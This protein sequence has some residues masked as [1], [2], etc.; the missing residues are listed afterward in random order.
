MKIVQINTFSNKSTGSIMMNIHKELLN[1]GHDSYVVWARGRKA[2]ND[3]EIFIGDKIGIILHGLFTRLTDKTGFASKNAT[4]KLLKSLDIIKPDVIHLHNIHGYYINIEL[5]FNYIKKNNIRTI[6]TLHDCWPFT[7]HCYNCEL[8]KCNKWKEEGCH[9]CPQTKVYPKSFKDNSKWN[10][11][12][13]KEIFTGVKDLTIVTPSNWLADLV[14]KSFLK[15]YNTV[16]I[17]NGVDTN[18]FKPRESDFR[19]KYNLDNKKIL[20]GVQ[21]DWSKLKGLDDFIELSK[22]ISDDYKI[23]L[24]GLNDKQLKEIPDNVIGIK[25]TDSAIQLAEIYTAA[26]VYLNLSYAEN[27]P[28]TNLEAQACGT[29]VVTYNVGG[30]PESAVEYGMVID[31]NNLLNNSV[32]LLNIHKNKKN[33][34]KSCLEMILDYIELYNG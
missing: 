14:G 6:W 5:L 34:D 20:L 11:S 19:E 2:E 7:G 33:V 15:D 22:V 8:S 26:D 1:Q 13:K 3:H 9:N 23:V 30:S 29:P 27:Y 24:V 4:K 12:K 25:R 32:R 17:N 21:S 31:K 16:V 10:F 18:I 28:T